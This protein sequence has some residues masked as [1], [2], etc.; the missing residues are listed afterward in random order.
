MEL[1]TYTKE[2][3]YMEKRQMEISYATLLDKFKD[4]QKYIKS[5][6]DKDGLLKALLIEFEKPFED[7]LISVYPSIIPA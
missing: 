3:G 6:L 7:G 2:G 1:Q 5:E 4:I